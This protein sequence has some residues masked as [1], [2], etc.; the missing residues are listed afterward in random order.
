MQTN[1][2]RAVIGA[3]RKQG[4][5]TAI[6]IIVVLIVALGLLAMSAGKLD[7]LF[8]GQGLAEEVSNVNTILANTKSL[9]TVSG[10]GAAGTDLTTQLVAISGIPKNMS[11]ITNVA[12]NSWGGAV[13]PAST[14][15]GFTITENSLPNDVCIKIATKTSKSGA[16]ATIKINAN[17]AIAG[18]VTSA[19]ATAQCNATTNT[20]VFTTS[21]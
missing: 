15:T 2:I 9:K 13:T 6:E 4:G 18:E 17:A 19:V 11:V 7:M 1:T 12:Y 10:Y 16:F 8:G 3:K 20:L 14:G 5:F 21:S